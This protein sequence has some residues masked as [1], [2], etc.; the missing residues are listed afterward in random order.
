[1]KKG[2]VLFYA[3]LILLSSAALSAKKPPK[4]NKSAVGNN[5]WSIGLGMEVADF[6]SPALKKLSTFKTPVA[7]GPRITMWRNFNSSVALGVDIATYA[8]STNSTDPS[9]PAL[10]T[11]NLLYSGLAAYKFN[12]GYIM[13]EDAAVAPYIFVKIQ[14]TWAETPVNKDR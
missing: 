6:Y 9:L 13:K 8:F 11:Y 1:M 3:L 5:R 14:G 2:I 12:N 10:N 7:F 4:N